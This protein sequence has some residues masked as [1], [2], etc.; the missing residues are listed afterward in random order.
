MPVRPVSRQ[1][2]WPR[3]WVWWLKKCISAGC[4][5]LLDVA[6]IGDRAVAEAPGEVGIGEALD[7]AGD[8]ASSAS[9]GRAQL[10]EIV[11]QDGVE[12]VR[13]L[14]R[15]GEAAHPDAVGDEEVVQRAVHRLEE[16]AAIGPV[17]GVRERRRGIVEPAVAQAL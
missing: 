13:A 6:R 16:R 7:I 11:E 10:R 5:R 8:A 2:A 9:R 12:P 4:E 3:W 15:A 1:C 17:V 14:A